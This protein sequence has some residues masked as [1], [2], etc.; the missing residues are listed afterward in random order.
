MSLQSL[1]DRLS[2]V[3]AAQHFTLAILAAVTD[4]CRQDSRFR[5]LLMERLEQHHSTLLHSKDEARLQAFQEL[6]AELLQE[7]TRR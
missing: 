7:D 2:K 3:E 1:S 6:K 4:I 5:T